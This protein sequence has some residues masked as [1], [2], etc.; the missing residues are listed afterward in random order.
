MKI[1]IEHS[2]PQEDYPTLI[3]RIP[4][5]S[6]SNFKQTMEANI[7]PDVE[8][9]I[10]YNLQRILYGLTGNP[11][12]KPKDTEEKTITEI[13]QQEMEKLIIEKLNRYMEKTIYGEGT[14]KDTT[15]KGLQELVTKEKAPYYEIYKGEE[16][17]FIPKPS[18]KLEDKRT[19][20]EKKLTAKEF[21][22]KLG[23]KLSEKEETK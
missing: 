6:R 8:Y 5:L 11:I 16:Y 20:E 3:L 15:I 21:L 13:S 23:E 2:D 9:N 17:N 7:P 14:I 18:L 4:N 1:I 22:Q 10:L 12:L 19:P